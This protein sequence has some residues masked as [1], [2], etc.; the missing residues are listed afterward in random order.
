VISNEIVVDI[1]MLCSL[2]YPLLFPYGKHG[3]HLGIRYLNVDNDDDDEKGREYVTMLEFVRHH[4]HYRL[5][6]ANLYTCYGRL[7]DQIVVDAYSM[8]K[9]S[10]LK[11]IA[12][13][14]RDL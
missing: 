11:F 12:D 6:E 8:I 5:H 9:G 3:F 7:S 14:Q 1:Y 10:R 13:R 2:Q 4:M